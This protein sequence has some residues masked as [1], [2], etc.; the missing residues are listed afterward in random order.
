ML[1]EYTW[2]IE[3]RLKE[4]TKRKNRGEKIKETLIF[5]SKKKRKTKTTQAKGRLHNDSVKVFFFPIALEISCNFGNS[6]ILKMDEIE[7]E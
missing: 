4:N 5:Y 7:L 3:L 2:S 1:T 6:S